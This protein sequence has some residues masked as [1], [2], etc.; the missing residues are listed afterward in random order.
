MKKA[1]VLLCTAL[2]LIGLMGC[3]GDQGIVIWSFTDEVEGLVMNYYAKAFPDVKINYS[4][5]P[6]DQFENRLDPVLASGR[7]APDVFALEAAFVRKYVESGLLLDLTDVYERNRNN[8]LAYTAEIGTF[9]GRVYGMSWQACPGAFFYR[10]SIARKYFNN[11]DPAFIQTL[12]SDFDR[13]LATAERLRAASNGQAVIL[14]SRGDLFNVFVDGRSQPWIVNNR[15][16]IDPVMI[17]YMEMS[18]QFHERGYDAK[19]NQWG[20]GWFRAMRDEEQ[21][22]SGRTYEAFGYF[23]P[24]WGL[25]YVL[26]PNAEATAGDWAMVEG[27]AA[28]RWGG[29]WLGAWK[30]TKK[31]DEVK[32]MIE[33]LTTDAGFLEE[34]AMASGDVVSSIPVMNKIAPNFSEPFLGGQNH[35]QAF[36]AMAQNVNGRLLQGTDQSINGIFGESVTA[37]V[38]GEMTLEEAIADFRAQVQSQL[39][40]N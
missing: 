13:F 36:A 27:P 5:T 22:A 31:V 30:G 1:L 28:Y 18:K 19:V 40:F 24:T 17:T 10:R 26:K 12:V 37:Y 6:T 23:L 11:D 35:Y 7:G 29:T 3:P 20:D 32:H 16:V 15:L 14:S 38:L 25:H 21:D 39:G 33:W 34:Y 4:F 9:E 8:L 2:M